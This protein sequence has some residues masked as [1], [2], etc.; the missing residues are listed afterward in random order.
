MRRCVLPSLWENQMFLIYFINAVCSMSLVVFMDTLLSVLIIVCS[1]RNLYLN[2]AE[3]WR[4]GSSF[5][6]VRRKA[7]SE[8]QGKAVGVYQFIPWLRLHLLNLINVS[9]KTVSP[10]PTHVV[11]KIDRYLKLLLPV[12]RS[13]SW[14]V[15]FLIIIGHPV[16]TQFTAFWPPVGERTNEERHLNGSTAKIEAPC[17]VQPLSK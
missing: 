5:Q 16:S 7:N 10:P 1:W 4:A 8:G 17:P 15:N 13:W 2:L 11:Y 9:Y 3:I 6:A 12:V 14:R